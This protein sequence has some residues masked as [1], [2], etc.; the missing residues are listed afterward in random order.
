MQTPYI[1]PGNPWENGCREHFN[2]RLRDELLA[3]EIFHTLREVQT[4]IEW[5]RR[6]Y[7]TKRSHSSLSFRPPEPE[8]VL[9]AALMPQYFADVAV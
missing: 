6:H 3:T 8:T 2:A 4:L 5:G 9:P 7:N 1:E